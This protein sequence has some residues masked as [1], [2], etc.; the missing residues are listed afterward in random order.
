MNKKIGLLVVGLFLFLI[1]GLAQENIKFKRSDFPDRK[2]EL[3]S[4]KRQIRYGDKAMEKDNDPQ[5]AIDHYQKAQE[6]NPDNAELNYKIGSAYLQS[7]AKTKALPYLEKAYKL[8]SD[9]MDE[10]ELLLKLGHARQLNYNFQDAIKAYSSYR[11]KFPKMGK[12]KKNKVNKRITECRNGIK[13]LKDTV[14]VKITNLGEKINTEYPEYNP[15]ILADGSRI[16]FTSRRKYIG[17]PIDNVDGQ[18]CEDVWYADK[19][20]DGTWSRAK[21]FKSPINTKGHDAIS[22]VSTDGQVMYVYKAQTEKGG[23]IFITE[24]DG[25]NWSNPESLGEPINTEYHESKVSVS[26]D[27]KT[28]YIVS[29]RP[30]G[31]FGGRDIFVSKKETWGSW[32]EPVNIGPV[33]NTEYDEEGVLIHPDG[34]TLY[35]CSQGHNSMGGFDIFRSVKDTNGNWSAPVNLG[36]PINTPDNEAFFSIAADGRHA[37][38]SSVRPDGYGSYDIYQIQYPEK[39]VEEEEE[40]QVTA[41]LTLFT[42]FVKDAKTMEPLKAKIEIVDNEKNEKIVDLTSNEATGKFVAS[43]PS[44]KN[45]G[46]SVNKEGYMFHSENFNIADTSEFEK[47]KKEVLLQPIEVGTKIVLKNIFFDYDKATLRESS[48]AELNKVIDVLN[49][50]PKLVIEISG[51]TDNRGSMEYNMNLSRE[52][53]KAVVEY[54]VKQGINK[55]RLKYKGYAFKQPIADNDTEKG[56]QLNRRVEFTV[57]END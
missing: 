21:R 5:K 13:L 36:Y 54:L 23:D 47:V 28:M 27:G 11:S 32:S 14:D 16:L 45:Y 33:I 22:G 3:R 39:E 24:Q 30:S 18:Y 38:I 51:H 52:R 4:A 50:N 10:D 1:S 26:Y 53:A 57:L 7:V 17:N 40:K 37:Y 8:D 49:E 41:R 35:F 56:R 6:F 43:L 25:N 48:Y 42:G 20:D 46:L 29:N 31:N 2:N 15:M 19:N 34:R 44:G 55:D 12:D 9:S